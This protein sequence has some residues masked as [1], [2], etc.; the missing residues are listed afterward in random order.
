M[1]C[2]EMSSIVI[3]VWPNYTHRLSLSREH[4]GDIHVHASVAAW[5]TYLDNK[6]NCGVWHVNRIIIFIT[7]HDMSLEIVYSLLSEHKHITEGYKLIT[8]IPGPKCNQGLIGKPPSH[9]ASLT[10]LAKYPNMLDSHLNIQFF[11]HN[12]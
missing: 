7:T 10:Q 5:N 11:T 1:Q 8:N 9:S 2:N 3:H 4:T 12:L 6:I